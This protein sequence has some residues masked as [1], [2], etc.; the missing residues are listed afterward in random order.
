[1]LLLAFLLPASAW[2]DVIYTD[3]ATNVKYGCVTDQ[4]GAY[5]LGGTQQES[6]I[7]PGHQGL[8][9]DITILETISYGGTT[10]TVTSIHKG[11]FMGNIDITSITIPASIDYIERAAFA[12]CIG[13]TDVYC[14]A[15]P[16]NLYWWIDN[17]W[18]PDFKPDKATRFHVPAS[19][20]STWQNLFGSANV[21]YV[22]DYEPGDAGQITSTLNNFDY[23]TQRFSTDESGRAWK[24]TWPADVSISGGYPTSL[25]NSSLGLGPTP[26]LRFALEG[27]YGIVRF[28][29]LSQ[30]PVTGTLK[31]I[32]VRGSGLSN[33]EATVHGNNY[34]WDGAYVEAG[35]FRDYIIDF[36]AAGVA[37]NDEQVSF[38]GYCDYA[39][40]INSIIL[41]MDGTAGEQIE[42]TQQLSGMTGD[43]TWEATPLGGTVG[44]WENGQTVS[45]PTYRLTISGN[46]YMADYQADYNTYSSDAPWFAL[47]GITE[48]VV[49]EGVVGLGSYAFYEMQSLQTAT[50]PSTLRVLTTYA[51]MNCGLSQV[52]L[53]EGV[54]KLEYGCFYSCSNLKS[55]NIPA[56]VTKIYPSAFQGNNLETVVVSAA[57]TVYDSRDNCNAII[58][59]ATNTLVVAT[60]GM[61]FPAGVTKVGPSAYYNNWNFPNIVI[62]EGVTEIGS[63]ACASMYS[64]LKSIQLPNSLTTIGDGAL[65][66]NTAITTI[67]LGSNLVSM[68]NNVFRNTPKLADVNCYADPAT[69]TWTNYESTEY[70]M[71]NKQTKFHVPAGYLEVWQSLFPDINATYVGDL[72]GGEQPGQ[73]VTYPY[74]VCGIAVTSEN[75]Q[76][77]PV[78]GLTGTISYFPTDN[79]FLFQN[80]FISAQPT[81]WT[82]VIVNNENVTDQSQPITVKLLGDNTFLNTGEA[83]SGTDITFMGADPTATLTVVGRKKAVNSFG[84]FT[85]KGCAL[86]LAS[87]ERAAVSCNNM[88]VN[89]G[90]SVS[91]TTDAA[92]YC[93]AEIIQGGLEMTD[94]AT[95]IN[96]I[97][98]KGKG[99]DGKTY[100]ML[101]DGRG[102][103]NGHFT[104]AQEVTI[105]TMTKDVV[106]NITYSFDKNLKSAAVTYPSN[107]KYSGA[108]TIPGIVTYKGLEY[109]VT[110]IEPK[111]FSESQ[112]TAVTLPSTLHAIGTTAFYGTKI[113][114]LNI[115]AEVTMIGTNIVGGCAQLATITVDATNEVFDSRENC[116]AIVYTATN[117]VWAGCKATTFPQSVTTIGRAS[118]L[119]HEELTEIDLPENITVIG[120]NSYTGATNVKTITL[121]G[122]V[123][124]ID[125]Y[126]FEYYDNLTDVY[127]YATTP[128]VAHKNAF[129]DTAIENVTL[130]V[131]AAAVDAYRAADVW[132][133]FKG[134]VAIGSETP[135]PQEPQ[136]SFNGVTETSAVLGEAFNAPVLSNPEKLEVKWASSDETVATVAAD[137]AVTLVGAGETVISAIWEGNDQWTAKTVSYKLTVTE[138]TTTEAKEPVLDFFGKTQASAVLG[139]DFQ[140]LELNN[141]ENLAVR[142]I[143]SNPEVAT[144][145]T[146]GAITL[147]KAGITDITAYWEG[148]DTWL[149]K[150]ALYRLTVTEPTTPEAQE[151]Q[152]DFGE[153]TEAIAVIGTEFQA[154]ELNNPEKLQ[155]TWTTSDATVASIDA[156]GT[157]VIQ[158]VGETIISAT[159]AGNEAWKAK[160]ASYKLIVKMPVVEEEKKTEV[161][162]G[163]VLDEN[164]DL[165]NV[166]IEEVLITLDTGDVYNPEEGS[167]VVQSVMTEEAVAE[168]ETLEPGTQEFAEKFSGMSFQVPAGMGVITLDVQTIGNRELAVKVGDGEVKKYTQS[169][170]GEIVINYAC[171]EPTWIFIFSMANA[172]ASA[173]PRYAGEQV[174]NAL[175]IFNLKVEPE[176]DYIQMLQ[177]ISTESVYD[178]QG[179]K[180]NVDASA[181]RNLP[182]GIYIV[183][184]KKV[185]F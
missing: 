164:T 98:F 157:I 145:A 32:I 158:G 107:G 27:Q 54:E 147:L 55:I 166:I 20:L 156:D 17:E 14:A 96:P 45:Y 21:T 97:V 179:R 173:K 56:S 29:F 68:G 140:P 184:G 69:L 33:V 128:P 112:V 79:V 81:D 144:I 25:S 120:F 28:D 18:Y 125:E 76:D 11:A 71:S 106:N 22:G 74:E 99:D 135:E 46:G 115:P 95:I 88:V 129:A 103:A 172:S 114:S 92:G 141:P 178:L 82:W 49:G 1:M 4:A 154:P 130:H 126:A 146:D 8:T 127:L 117:E 176:A 6:D 162:F 111:A 72:G 139:E 16:N 39:F 177:L 52:T 15:D 113:T 148:D 58:E 60:P 150:R 84:T 123:T 161:D 109:K 83:F 171:T 24:M 143:S 93:A 38:R 5:V 78:P 67:T 124:S 73:T 59:T 41:V 174:D 94:G 30:F 119:W 108:I 36:G 91:M 175:K 185:I 181:L 80:C 19:Y 152:L 182:K 48:V 10:Y 87:N 34:F 159:F 9:G 104:F 51:F 116:N 151:P 85:V 35:V 121:R 62:P 65:C 44:V 23:S 89:N 137:G 40:F 47:K 170:R 100:F 160:T 138:S 133:N 149:P 105:G 64:G 37:M 86:T 183:N 163:E 165:S 3:P 155:V 102:K 167:V 90:G 42:P 180:V 77:I 136:L 13:V 153:V 43:L 142:W 66:N 2:A 134:V 7:F 26:C 61:T 122:Q 31:K 50:L 101:D 75:C 57:N 70:F 132:K 169:E 110:T 53:P 168:L 12:R 131:P 63:S 118:F